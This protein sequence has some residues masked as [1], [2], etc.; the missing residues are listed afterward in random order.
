MAA[1]VAALVCE[2]G[3]DM[4]DRSLIAAAVLAATLGLT[5]AG[6]RAFDEAKYPDWRGQWSRVPVAGLSRNP[7]WD[8]HKSEGLAQQA[9]LTPEYQAILEASLADQ[10]AGGAGLDRDFT[11]MTAGMPRMMNVY[12]TMESWSC[13]TLPSC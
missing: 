10:T 7:S 13:R 2:E 4:L 6:A 5:I 11:C 12:S 1:G 3:M 9:P 8:P